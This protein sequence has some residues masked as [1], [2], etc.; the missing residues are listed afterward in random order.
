MGKTRRCLL[1]LQLAALCVG[2]G[3][4]LPWAFRGKRPRRVC[5]FGSSALANLG[6]SFETLRLP[7]PGEARP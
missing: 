7:L 3:L 2:L 6:E 4:L 5:A 1:D